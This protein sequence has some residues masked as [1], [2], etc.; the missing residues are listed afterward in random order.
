MSAT[1]YFDGSFCDGVGYY[2][3]IIDN[4]VIT[5]KQGEIENCKDSVTAEYTALILGLRQA[6]DYGISELVI[7][8]DS[9]TVLHQL[10]GQI[11]TRKTIPLHTE[12]SRL[13]N[14]MPKFTIEWIPSRDNPADLL[15]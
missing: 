2:G 8:G 1:L 10:T 14:L 7:K 15:F 3:F 5:E 13:L 12:A 11:K 6:I 9:K 4:S